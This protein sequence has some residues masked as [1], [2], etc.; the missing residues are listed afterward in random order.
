MSDGQLPGG[1]GIEEENVNNGQA[2]EMEVTL[3]E[4]NKVENNRAVKERRNR[5]VSFSITRKLEEEY[6]M[7][8]MQGENV[9]MFT[10]VERSGKVR[11][12]HVLPRRKGE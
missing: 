12:K 8:W 1:N 10:G 9:G 6:E 2:G 7:D 5:R 3:E 4:N 11:R